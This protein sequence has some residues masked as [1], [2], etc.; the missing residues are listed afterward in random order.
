[1]PSKR[2]FSVELN[3]V[4]LAEAQGGHRDLESEIRAVIPWIITRV[5]VARDPDELTIAFAELEADDGLF[6]AIVG[7]ELLGQAGARP[8]VREWLCQYMED[9][10]LSD[11]ARYQLAGA[12][13]RLGVES[14]ESSRLPEAIFFARQG[15][16]VIADL[17]YRAVTSNLYYN[18][19]T[20]L[21][22][23]GDFDA[24]IQAFDDSADVDELIGRGEDAVQSRQ[25]IRLLRKFISP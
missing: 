12:Y 1:M 10:S 4:Y 7:C 5:A 16:S 20:A 11:G 3:P 24:A 25:R 6:A 21:E 9:R 14:R 13:S 15:L 22:A 18:L 8:D 2:A 17:P 19:G 23:E